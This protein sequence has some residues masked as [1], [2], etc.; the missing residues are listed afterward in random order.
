MGRVS[1]RGAHGGRRTSSV[2]DRNSQQRRAEDLVCLLVHHISD[3][4]IF[5]VDP[6]ATILSWNVGAESCTGYSAHE[7]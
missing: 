7:M 1:K 3:L 6:R 5:A 2:G 4:A